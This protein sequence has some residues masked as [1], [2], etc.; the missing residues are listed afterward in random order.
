MITFLNSLVKMRVM[1]KPRS[2]KVSYF[3][4][5]CFLDFSYLVKLYVLIKKTLLKTVYCVEMAGNE[6]FQSCATFAQDWNFIPAQITRASYFCHFSAFIDL[7]KGNVRIYATTR[8]SRLFH[9]INFTEKNFHASRKGVIIWS[10]DV[11]KSLCLARAD[12]V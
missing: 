11:T 4:N 3:L 12:M 7:G 10:K 9:E 2:F 8:L 5:P 1:R 6:Q